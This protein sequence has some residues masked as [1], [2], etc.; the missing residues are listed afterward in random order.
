MRAQGGGVFCNP[1]SPSAPPKLRVLYETLPLAFVVEAAG[2]AA[3]DG[4]GPALDRRLRGHD[5]RSAVCLGSSEEVA[6]CAAA[7]G[8]VAAS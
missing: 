8:V 2:G 3:T 4:D 1:V 5:D 6:K 7:M